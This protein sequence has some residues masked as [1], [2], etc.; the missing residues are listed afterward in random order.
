MRDSNLKELNTYDMA[1]NESQKSYYAK[2][3][4]GIQFK[5]AAK[6]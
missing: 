5:K 3:M 4:C 6:Y 1:W 2:A